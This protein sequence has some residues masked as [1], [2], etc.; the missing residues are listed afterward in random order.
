MDV[1]VTVGV[2]LLTVCASALDFAA[3]KFVSPPYDAVIE[4]DPPP[5]D[6][7]ANFALPL[8]NVPVLSVV[9][10]SRNVTVPV[11]VPPEP[12]TTAVKVTELP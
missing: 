6:A 11:G 4:C 5:N 3:L 12:D 1:R 8:L 7:V 2:A 9:V 10:P